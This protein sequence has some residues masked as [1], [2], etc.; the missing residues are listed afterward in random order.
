MILKMFV[1]GPARIPPC[2]FP[3]RG[4]GGGDRGEAHVRRRYVG[5]RNAVARRGRAAGRTTRATK[6]GP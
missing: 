2:P 1:P 3:R 6:A 4:Q 5:H